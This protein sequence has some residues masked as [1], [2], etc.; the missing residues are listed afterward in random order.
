MKKYFF[1]SPRVLAAV[2]TAERSVMSRQGA[3]IRRRARTDILRRTA[4]KTGRRLVARGSDGRFMKTKQK[5][6]GRGQPPIVRS[7]DKSANLRNI[8]FAYNPQ[9]HSVVIGPV[10][11][12]KRPK[13]SSAQTVPELLEKG[14]TASVVQWAGATGNV[15]N[16]GSTT[17][18]Y[19]RRRTVRGHY[20]PHP[21]MG[22]ALAKEVAAGTIVGPWA[23][24]VM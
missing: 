9:G 4:G 1:D 11:L 24:K 3:F 16:F 17:A 14:G 12:N 13:N 22:P 5:V 10:G 21:F 15:W 19:F 23:G 6:A 7:R 8:L 18:H 2:V 20:S